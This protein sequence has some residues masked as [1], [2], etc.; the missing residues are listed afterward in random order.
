MLQ[1]LEGKHPIIEL[2]GQYRE[3]TKLDSTYLSA[4]PELVDEA[5]PPAHHARPDGGRDRA[6]VV[7][8]PQPA[9]HPHPHA[10]RARDP[11]RVHHRPGLAAS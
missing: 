11:R 10:A 6:P 4:L 7:E 5:G 3:L 8:Q 9:E 1:L 2:I